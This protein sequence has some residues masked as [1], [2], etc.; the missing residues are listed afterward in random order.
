MGTGMKSCPICLED[1]SSTTHGSDGHPI[2][3][4]RCGHVFDKTCYQEWVSSGNGDVTKCP[5]CRID[6]GVNFNIPPS[7][8]S[9]VSH[10]NIRSFAADSGSEGDDILNDDTGRNM[11][12]V[13]ESNFENN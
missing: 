6:V 1:F 2:Q 12:S 10:L 7:R 13:T 3:L 8:S 5:I 4:L 9:M 11:N